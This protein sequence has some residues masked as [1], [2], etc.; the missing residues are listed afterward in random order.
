MGDAVD[1]WHRCLNAL[2][3]D[4]PSQQFNT[5]IR[6]L[7]ASLPVNDT[8]V[9]HAPNRFVADWV[10]DKYLHKIDALL[11]S[12]NGGKAL[13]L[14]LEFGQQ[15]SVPSINNAHSP[16]V[17][18]VTAKYD[19]TP[20]LVIAESKFND[21]LE[22]YNEENESPY[23]ADHL[24]ANDDTGHHSHLNKDHT[25]ETFV[26][27]KSNQ[28]AKAAALQVAAN[29]GGSYNP[30]LLYGSV[31]LGKTHL[32]HAVGNELLRKNPKARILYINSDKFMADMI[33]AYQLDAI[34][35]FKRYYHGL[36]ALLV[37]DIQFFANKEG[38]QEQFFSAF[39]A[40]T[41]GGQQ[42][43]LTSDKFPKEIKGLDERLKSRFS[44]GLTVAIESPELETRVAILMKKAEQLKTKLPRDAA[45]YIAQ[46]IRSNVRELEGALKRVVVTA[47]L[48]G[49]AIDIELIKESLKDLFSIHDRLVS[50]DNIQKTV[51]EYYKIKLSDLLSKRR[52]R[53]LARPRQVA[54]AIARELTNHSLPE[55]GD[56]FGGR[57]HTTVL[58]ACQ[59]IQELRE[60]QQGI[61]EDVNNLL[62]ILTT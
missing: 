17:E 7:Q 41:N 13:D 55:I 45:F 53:S 30:L 11:Q 32:M 42:I 4:L 27:G 14:S 6:P 59:K 31:G 24:F 56:A 58:H 50:I 51:A 29:P 1:L 23:F 10:R 2:Q 43:I 18:T 3:D 54:M 61:E 19:A 34:E 60:S 40:L 62:R 36:D 48:K 57:D 37:D 52:T 39:N 15:K 9:L 20:E 22:Y 16:F 26:E 21:E 25:F 47:E 28:L 5:W 35:D 33:K 49:R 38:T 12:L 44:W 8:L 46:R